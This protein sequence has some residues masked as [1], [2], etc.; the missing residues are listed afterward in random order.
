MKLRTI[1]FFFLLAMAILFISCEA[2][3]TG[4]L[5]SIEQER[6]IDDNNLSN[7]LTAGQILA[8][9]M[10]AT[11]VYDYEFF[12]AAGPIYNVDATDN[13]AYA[14]TGN[15]AGEWKTGYDIPSDKLS[16]RVFDLG[17][18]TYAL[19]Y[20]K[21][22][23]AEVTMDSHLYKLNGTTWDLESTDGIS[24]LIIEDGKATGGVFYFT[25]YTLDGDNNRT[26]SIGAFDGTTVTSNVAGASG[27]SRS[28]YFDAAS[29]GGTTYIIYGQ[30]IFSDAFTAG[31]EEV[32]PSHASLNNIMGDDDLPSDSTLFR[33]I[34]YSTVYSKFFLSTKD[35][36]LWYYDDVTDNEWKIEGSKISDEPFDFEDF[37][38]I[39]S[40]SVTHNMLLVGTEDGYYEKIGALGA[41]DFEKP[42]VSCDANNYLTLDLRVAVVNSLFAHDEDGD[43]TDEVLFALTS[44]YGLWSNREIDGERVWNQE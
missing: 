3:E 27:L 28:A 8:K 22:Q 39:D 23:P 34:H 15:T 10:D 35:G 13:A 37:S 12:L 18:E 36:S 26:Y 5:Y 33:G 21:N 31:M 2:Q 24:S 4:L 41:G 9:D 20:A 25:T 43:G 32:L 38:F 7:Q 40:S 11:A 30:K 6:K 1:G 16:F 29:F 42:S 44:G 19:L 14:Q 17:G